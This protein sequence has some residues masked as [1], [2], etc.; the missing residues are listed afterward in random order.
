MH[1]AAA[2]SAQQAEAADMLAAAQQ[3]IQVLQDDGA[4]V[5]PTARCDI[6]WMATAAALSGTL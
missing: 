1:A 5:R 4:E 2:V 3:L 6:H